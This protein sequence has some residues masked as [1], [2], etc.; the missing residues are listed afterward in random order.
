MAGCLDRC[1]QG[2]VV[3]VY[4]EEVWYKLESR[5]DVDEF[6]DSHLIKGAPV[7]RLMI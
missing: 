1:G 4:P 5:A 2:P 6:I 3:V 7:E